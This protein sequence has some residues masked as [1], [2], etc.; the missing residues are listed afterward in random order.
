[1]I[2]ALV[3]AMMGW[4]IARHPVRQP[5]GLIVVFAM[6]ADACLQAE[7]PRQREGR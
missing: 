6:L 2:D 1:M 3:A 5:F 4:R 7:R